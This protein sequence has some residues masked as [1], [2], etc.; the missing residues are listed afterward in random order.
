MSEGKVP[1]K[2]EAT[3]AKGPREKPATIAVQVKKEGD[4][5]DFSKDT[6][7]YILYLMYKSNMISRVNL[8][9]MFGLIDQKLPENVVKY[10]LE[11]A[12]R[13]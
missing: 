5:L 4:S 12:A 8:K 13:A 1:D 11:E 9:Q 2:V 7:F 3:V 6:V 10:L